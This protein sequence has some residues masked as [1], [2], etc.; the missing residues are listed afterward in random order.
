MPEDQAAGKEELFMECPNCGREMTEGALY[1]EHCGEDI[2]IVPDFEPEL[3]ENIQQIIEGIREDIEEEA[4]PNDITESESSKKSLSKRKLCQLLVLIAV[5]VLASAVGMGTWV[6]R[7]NS[8]EYQV[9]KAVQY[10]SLEEYEKAIAC[11]NRA[12]EL[13]EDNI[14]LRFELAEVYFLKN[15]K[16]EYEYLLRE[17]VKNEKAS[18]EQLDRAY[19][20]L[21]AIYR[22]RE[23]YETINELLLGSNNPELITIYAGYTSNPPEFSVI[24]GYYTSIQAL[25]LTAVGNGR[26]YFTLDGEEPDEDSLQY[27]MPILLENGDYV[28]KA[29]FINEYGIASDV[30]SKEY[31]IDNDVILAPE[32]NINSGTYNTP[33]DIEVLAMEEEDSIYYTT[34]GSTPDY[35]SNLYT[36]AIHMPLGRSTFKFARIVDGVTGDVTERFYELILNTEFSEDLAYS[37]I[38]EYALSSGRILDHEGHFGDTGDIYIYEYLYVININQV[39]DFYVFAEVQR[40]IDGAQVRTGNFFAV[41]AYSGTRYKLQQSSYGGYSLEAIDSL[42]VSE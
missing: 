30:V 33:M 19:G 27:T 7:Y 18:N 14:E 39:S 21:I 40:D 11:Y 23:D 20:R 28:V 42:E 6:Y 5:L 25:K 16:I 17:I 13:D 35:T 41:D 38:V 12:L 36:Q 26:I 1:C 9:S 32:V 22:D 2:H 3:E 37:A 31:H 4:L 29:I 24:E 10:V 8:E 15:N 34:D